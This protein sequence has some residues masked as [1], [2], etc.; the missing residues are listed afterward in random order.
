MTNTDHNIVFV[1]GLSGAGLSSALKNFEDLGY[2]VLDNFPLTLLP[3]LLEKKA[4][5]PIAIGID[6]RTRNFSPTALKNAIQEHHAKLVFMHCDDPV[7]QKRFTETR[8]KHPLAQ[9]R[10]VNAGIEKEKMLMQQLQSAADLL[11]DTSALSIH[12][13]RRIIEGHFAREK[14][15]RLSVSLMSFGFRGGIPA[16]A[17]IV[18]DVRFLKN[19]HWDEGLRPLNGKD[20]SVQKY[21]EEDT[22]FVPFLQN[23]QNMLEPLL[24]RYAHE[25]K[26]YLTI[27]IGCTG[28]KHRSVFVIEKLK[29]WF[30]EKKIKA[31]LKHRDLKD[32]K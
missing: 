26:S 20:A 12:D 15:Q 8:R 6:S 5:K 27:A 23:F 16:S 17:D 19:P 18:M 3:P 29:D 13:L 9:D 28:G 2:E 21:I 7:L 25:G 22:N 32:Q 1:T 14:N 10:P 11:I 31:Y 24:E 4:T 30:D